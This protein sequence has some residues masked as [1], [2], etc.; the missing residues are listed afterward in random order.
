MG[1]LDTTAVDALL[2]R[3]RRD[4][5]DGLLPSC[6]VALGLDGKV[7]VHEAFGDASLDT[8]YTIFSATKP[9][10]ASVVW[11]LLG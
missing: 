1:T 5:D 8:R 10:V 3:A 2:D 7:V 6:Q 11:Q 9:F 4:V